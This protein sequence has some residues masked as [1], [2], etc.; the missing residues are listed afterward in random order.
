MDR[1]KPAM[2]VHNMTLIVQNLAQIEDAVIEAARR[3]DAPASVLF[4]AAR[5]HAGRTWAAQH[6]E[7]VPQAQ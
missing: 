7:T 3:H 4:A 2:T 6:Q 5:I 1:G